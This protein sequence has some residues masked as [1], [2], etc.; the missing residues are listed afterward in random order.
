[1]LDSNPTSHTLEI[2]SLSDY[3]SDP[4]PPSEDGGSDDGAPKVKR[5]K[6]KGKKSKA[7]SASSGLRSLSAADSTASARA[8]N[9]E[10]MGLL[11]QEEEEK[12]R[13]RSSWRPFVEPRPD[14]PRR[15]RL[16]ECLRQE[17]EPE[18]EPEPEP[19][20]AP[21]PVSTP[22]ACSLAP[23]PCVTFA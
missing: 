13:T 22:G 10:R 7:K 8:R 5:T 16:R 20:P 21:P 4:P 12:V 23:A 15:A 1:M 9:A 19:A 11:G 17:E 6:S 14:A 18:P 3:S 2:P